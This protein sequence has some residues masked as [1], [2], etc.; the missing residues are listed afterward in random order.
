LTKSDWPPKRV[1]D[2]DLR[3]DLER[4]PARVGG[5]ELGHLERVGEVRVDAAGRDQPL[6]LDRDELGDGA[7]VER[8]HVV[9]AGLDEP[10]VDELLD[11]VGMLRREIV[12][13]GPVL[14]GVEQQPPAAG[15]PTA[16]IRT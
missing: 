8:E 1:G 12:R 4:A 15:E 14:V 10:E 16:A 7:V 5:C 2:L 3:E 11:L 6:G 9:L 13:L